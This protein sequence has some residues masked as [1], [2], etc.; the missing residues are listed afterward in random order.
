MFDLTTPEEELKN[1]VA[2]EFFADFD[3]T[4]RTNNI[5][6]MV[7]LKNQ[8]IDRKNY[9]L[10]AEAKKGNK[11]DIYASIVQLIL[12]IGKAN[13]EI[14][15]KKLRAP[16]FFGAFDAQRF[17]ILPYSQIMSVFTQ[18]DFNWSVTPSNH[19]SGEFKQLYAMIKE[20]LETESLIFDFDKHSDELRKFI[21]ENF[22][23]NNATTTKI[24]INKN[25]LK[26]VYLDWVEIVKQGFYC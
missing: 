13:G 4:E 18:S 7:A 19:E 8:P 3:T 26:N 6:F 23:L 12:T 14:K 5:D 9:Y 25:N 24:Q 11:S 20:T 17:A 22:T 21:R 1:K 10:W 15:S 2:V 16:S